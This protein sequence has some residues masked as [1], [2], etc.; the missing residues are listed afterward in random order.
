MHLDLRNP[1]S[2]RQKRLPVCHVVHEQNALGAAE[3]RR[4]DGAEAL[5]AGGVPDLQLD[6]LVVQ[7]NVLDLDVNGVKIGVGVEK[8]AGFRQ[9]HVAVRALPR[10]VTREGAA[11]DRVRGQVRIRPPPSVGGGGAVGY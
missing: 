9:C 6:A 8:G 7:L 11:R 10:W 2:Y 1:V 3:V 4:G 5:L